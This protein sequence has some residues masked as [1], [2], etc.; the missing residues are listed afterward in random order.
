MRRLVLKSHITL[1]DPSTWS[2]TSF[3]TPRFSSWMNQFSLF[4]LQDFFH[5]SKSMVIYKDFSALPLAS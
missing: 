3:S 4:Q 5:L 2:Y 1:A